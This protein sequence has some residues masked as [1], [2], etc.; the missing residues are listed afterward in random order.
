MHY[1]LKFVAFRWRKGERERREGKEV[2][3]EREVRREER[4]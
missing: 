1:E 4:R 2:E 3:G